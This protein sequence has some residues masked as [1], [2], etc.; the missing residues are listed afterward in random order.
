MEIYDTYIKWA[1]LVIVW[2]VAKAFHVSMHS[3]M[4]YRI[5]S[6]ASLLNMSNGN[7]L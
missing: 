5:L 3:L 1:W 4:L 2:A 6:K 7:S